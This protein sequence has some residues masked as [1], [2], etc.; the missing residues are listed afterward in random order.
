MNRQKDPKKNRIKENNKTSVGGGGGHLERLL[1]ETFIGRFRRRFSSIQRRWWW[2][3]FYCFFW[4]NC[5]VLMFVAFKTLLANVVD[6]VPCSWIWNRVDCYESSRLAWSSAIFAGFFYCGW[7]CFAWVWHRFTATDCV[8]K[9]FGWL[10]LVFT[11]SQ[12]GITRFFL[13]VDFV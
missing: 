13:R 1:N 12:L 11:V 8:S 7:S 4:F 9:T 3:L 10:Y 6:C 5:L 2:D